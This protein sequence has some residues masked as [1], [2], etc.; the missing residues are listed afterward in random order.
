MKV[1][2]LLEG[3]PETGYLNLCPYT[4]SN[5]DTFQ[6]GE[7]TKLDYLIDDGEVEELKAIDILEYYPG[8]MSEIILTNWIKKLKHGGK[9]VLGT[10]DLV[11][12]AKGVANYELDID[13]AN[14]FFHGEQKRSWDFRL[15][16]FTMN[17]IV[18]YLESK[19]LKVIKKRVNNYRCIIEAIRL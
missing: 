11:E 10:V 14:L 13:Q 5:T 18:H 16:S 17:Q 12:V 9:L 2:L 15:S 4:E 8:N 7:V 1:N 3:Q 19:D 6:K